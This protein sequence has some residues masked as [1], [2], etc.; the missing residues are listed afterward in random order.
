MSEKQLIFNWI[1]FSE[2]MS[3]LMIELRPNWLN[4]VIKL[5]NPNES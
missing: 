1:F 3:V 4:L 5:I 2:G